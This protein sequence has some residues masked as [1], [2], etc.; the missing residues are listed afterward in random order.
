MRSSRSKAPQL[1]QAR[2]SARLARNPL[3]SDLDI[4]ALDG[5]PGDTVSSFFTAEVRGVRCKSVVEGLAINGLRVLWKS[6][7]DRSRQIAVRRVG[8]LL[9]FSWTTTKRR[10]DHTAATRRS[11][12]ATA[13]AVP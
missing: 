7:P 5:S 1:I 2:R 6:P 12:A 11:A 3:V 4:S 9:T 10:I 8:H 13:A